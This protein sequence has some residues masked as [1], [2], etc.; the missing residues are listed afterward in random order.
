M[1]W[2][3]NG[4]REARVTLWPEILMNLIWKE[5]GLASKPKLVNEQQPVL[6]GRLGHVWVVSFVVRTWYGVDLFLPWPILV[7]G[8]W[9]D[10]CSVKFCMFNSRTPRPAVSAQRQGLP[11]PSSQSVC[12]EL[13]SSSGSRGATEQD[14][15]WKECGQQE[16]GRR[17]QTGR[18]PPGGCTRPGVSLSQYWRP[19]TKREGV[20]K[21]DSER[22]SRH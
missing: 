5:A 13:W 12:S 21:E 11:T 4:C 14:C 18:S 6:W 17:R 10:V 16:G 20:C 15:G 9:S 8:A 19:Q 22:I 2:V 3:R 7:A 1:L